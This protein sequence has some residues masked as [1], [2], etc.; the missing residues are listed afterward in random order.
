MRYIHNINVVMLILNFL[1]LLSYK[2]LFS[3]NYEQ[4]WLNSSSCISF[5]FQFVNEQEVCNAVFAIKSVEID[6]MY[7]IFFKMI[8]SGVLPC[9]TRF[10]DNIIQCSSFSDFWKFAKSYLYAY[11]KKIFFNNDPVTSYCHTTFFD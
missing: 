7:N 8:I 4:I 10:F 9:I 1:I 5:S 2:H 6:Y 11:I 3:V